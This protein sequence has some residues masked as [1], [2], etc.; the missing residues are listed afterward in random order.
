VKHIKSGIFQLALYLFFCVTMHIKKFEILKLCFN[1][2]G[3]G[4]V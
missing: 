4:G 1:V 2:C 3:I